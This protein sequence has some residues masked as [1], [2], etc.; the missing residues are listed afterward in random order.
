MIQ[1][2]DGTHKMDLSKPIP[3]KASRK[4]ASSRHSLHTFLATPERKNAIQ[5]IAI[6]RQR[7]H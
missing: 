3:K 4:N 5:A 6:E 2:P 7:V 1:A